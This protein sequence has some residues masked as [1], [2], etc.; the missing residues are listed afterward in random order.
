MARLINSSVLLRLTSRLW[1]A[2]LLTY[3]FVCGDPNAHPIAQT[4]VNAPWSGGV[5]VVGADGSTFSQ[6]APAICPNDAPQNCGNINIWNWCCT[7]GTTCAMLS[8][9]VVGC[10]PS[11]SQCSGNINAAAASTVTVY[12]SYQVTTTATIAN[13]DTNTV[14]VTEAA[15]GGQFCSTLFAKGPNLPT[16]AQGDCGTILVENDSTSV[17]N[18]GSAPLRWWATFWGVGVLIYWI[19]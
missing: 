2:T 1:V 9:G 10:C 15:A 6:A 5:Y 7:S 19:R 17:W 3:S 14:P 12:N 16:T 8:N 18:S 11:G 4:N 13:Q